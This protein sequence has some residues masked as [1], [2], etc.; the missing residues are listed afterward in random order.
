MYLTAVDVSSTRP[1]FYQVYQRDSSTNPN[2]KLVFINNTAEEAG[3]AL[4]GGAA[5]NNCVMQNTSTY[6]DTEPDVVFNSLFNITDF[7]P[8]RSISSMPQR[9]CFCAHGVQDC[10]GVLDHKSISVYPGQRF[11]KEFTVVGLENGAVPGTIHTVF[12]PNSHAQLGPLQEAQ[13][14]GRG[15]QNLTFNIYSSS[16]YEMLRFTVEYLDTI[17]QNSTFTFLSG[18]F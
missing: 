11:Q 4:F 12:L 10:I 18:H 13:L 9:P 15:C 6:N 14:V 1:C 5:I 8:I 3:D 17:E 2:V 7:N 16:S